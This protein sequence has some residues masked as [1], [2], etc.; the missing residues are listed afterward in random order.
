MIQ[1]DSYFYSSNICPW[2]VIIS[3]LTI[4]PWVSGSRSMCPTAGQWCVMFAIAWCRSSLGRDC[5]DGIKRIW[6]VWEER[7]RWSCPKG[8]ALSSN[9]SYHMLSSHFHG[10]SYCASWKPLIFC[11]WLG[12]DLGGSPRSSGANP[13]HPGP[14]WA[15]K[16]APQVSKRWLALPWR[17]QLHHFQQV[18][19][20]SHE[21]VTHRRDHKMLPEKIHQMG[22]VIL[23]NT[24]QN[25]SNEVE[26]K[27]LYIYIQITIIYIYIYK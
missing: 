26:F 10:P 15:P 1:Y 19:D 16:G 13:G 8:V 5:K 12:G 14:S 9:L 27:Y 2:S 20:L 24:W 7:L 11:W 23:V 22:K 6:E 3:G 4:G 21:E 18:G 17:A 25:D